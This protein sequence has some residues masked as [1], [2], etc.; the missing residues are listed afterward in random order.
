MK[1]NFFYVIVVGDGNCREGVEKPQTGMFTLSENRFV[2]KA[3]GSARY[4]ILN[5]VV[6]II[7]LI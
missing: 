4:T 2:K 1:F 3:V 6:L 5:N 7:D